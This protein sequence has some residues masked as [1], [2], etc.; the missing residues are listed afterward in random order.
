MCDG[1]GVW[2]VG[3]GWL[4]GCWVLGV[5]GLCSFPKVKRGVCVPF[6]VQLG[7][8]GEAVGDVTTS[9][10]HVT[11]S[12]GKSDLRARANYYTETATPSRGSLPRPESESDPTRP[13]SGRS[14][15]WK[16]EE[17]KRDFHFSRKLETLFFSIR[18]TSICIAKRRTKS[19]GGGLED[20]KH[21]CFCD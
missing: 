1:L 10:G 17:K 9:R 5:G 19:C 15:L 3:V 20:R 18:V 12:L 7:E 16:K 2:L 14:V 11:L 4:L 21:S 6:D 8:A 13:F